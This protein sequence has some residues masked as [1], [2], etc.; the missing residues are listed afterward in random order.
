MLVKDDCFPLNASLVLSSILLPLNQ[1][2]QKK[3]E[4]KF[5]PNSSLRC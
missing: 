1:E 4:I 3:A 2:V 5:L